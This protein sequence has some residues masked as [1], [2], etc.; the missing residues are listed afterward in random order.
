MDLPP[1]AS[2]VSAWFCPALSVPLLL[3]ILTVRGG[4]VAAT[5]VGGGLVEGSSVVTA[6]GEGWERVNRNKRQSLAYQ[7]IATTSSD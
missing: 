6:A 2:H 3:T 1:L 4:I 7:D 5:V